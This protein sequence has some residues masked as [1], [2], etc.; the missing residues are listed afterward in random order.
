MLIK[1]T[2]DYMQSK[3]D[4]EVDFLNY[5]FVEVVSRLVFIDHIDVY[6]VSDTDPF[7]RCLEHTFKEFDCQTE[8]DLQYKSVVDDL[9]RLI[10]RDFKTFNNA[11]SKPCKS[12]IFRMPLIKSSSDYCEKDSYYSSFCF[13][14]DDEMKEFLSNSELHFT[15][16]DESA[17][18]F[19]LS[20]LYLK[21]FDI[22]VN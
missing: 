12:L 3:L 2:V 8:S 9:Y 19:E 16:L 13:V 10:M 22:E 11:N 18:R 4:R 7:Y 6:I 17:I 14:S 1:P 5:K 15:K 21:A 20:Q